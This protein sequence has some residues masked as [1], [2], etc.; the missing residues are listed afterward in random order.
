MNEETI[1]SIEFLED[2]INTYKTNN[3]DREIECFYLRIDNKVC[4]DFEIILKYIKK[5]KGELI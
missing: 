3:H 2:I 1:K 4:E 5:G